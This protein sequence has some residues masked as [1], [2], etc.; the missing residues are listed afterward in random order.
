MVLD[1]ERPGGGS[2]IRVA[3]NP[4]KLGDAPESG[5]LR[6]PTLGEHTDEVLAED[7]GMSPEEIAELRDRG[8]VG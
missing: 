7:L 8:V 3:G 4:I 6:W 5:P 2:P 1:V